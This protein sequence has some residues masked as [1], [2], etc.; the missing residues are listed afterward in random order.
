VDEAT[1]AEVI[2]VGIGIRDTQLLL[3]NERGSLA[4]IGEVG[5]IGVR[6]RFLSEGYLGEAESTG[7]RFIPSPFTG[8]PDDVIYLTGDYGVYRED[9]AVVLR[10]RRDDQIKIRGFRVELSDV[11]RAIEAL[12]GVRSALALPRPGINGETL[13]V[14]FIA[15]DEGQRASA[16]AGLDGALADRLPAYMI[17]A[18]VVWVDRLPLLPNGKIDRQALVA[19]DTR[20]APAIEPAGSAAEADLARQWKRI[21]GL[22]GIPGKHSFVQMGGDSLSY[23]Q[24]ARAV[25][26]VLGYL[27]QGWDHLPFQ[28]LARLTPR[29]RHGWNAIGTTILVRALSITAVVLGHFKIVDLGLATPALFVVAGW[30]FARFQLRASIDQG[31]ILPIL[32]ST[33]K[34]VLP[35]AIAVA[36]KLW[37]MKTLAT[38]WPALFMVSN[39]FPHWGGTP[40]NGGVYVAGFWFID[41]L[42]QIFLLLAV[43]FAFPRA[44]SWYSA[45]PFRFS[46]SATALAM[47][48]GGG[49]RFVWDTRYLNN[50]VP[51]FGLWMVFLGMA[52]LSATTLRK[53]LAIVAIAA[54]AL[55]TGRFGLFSFAAVLLAVFVERLPMPSIL[56]TLTTYLAASSLFIYVT[57]EMIHAAIQRASGNI[58]PIVEFLGALSI[59]VLIQV[60]WNQVIPTLEHLWGS[61]RRTAP[62]STSYEGHPN[63]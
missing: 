1:D 17:P 42:V 26:A 22:P 23:M 43:L 4:A 7:E 51:H 5:Q 37:T 36:C 13:L 24:A 11:T 32:K 39:Y 10:G 28:A 14:A 30:S 47:V 52:L 46:V 8:R 61:R 63:L 15:T 58:P 41:V 33:W 19:M 59:G 3:I 29:K 6:T 40:E 27:P 62:H 38:D 56:A 21:L 55:A 9:G 45:H 35:T 31:N 54:I 12:P 25:E 49:L 53:K 34:I 18:R 50:W 20:D 57:H 44:R 16:Q 48:V 60:A 2:P